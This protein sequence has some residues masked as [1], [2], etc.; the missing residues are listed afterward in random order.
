MPYF[1]LR[2]AANAPVEVPGNSEPEVKANIANNG[3]VTHTAHSRSTTPVAPQSLAL[4][5]AVSAASVCVLCRASVGQVANA[6]LAEAWVAAF[7]VRRSHAILK[8]KAEQAGDEDTADEQ[9]D[10][11]E[12]AAEAE[13][14]ARAK[15]YAS[16]TA[17]P[18]PHA[19]AADTGAA[20]ANTAA[21][22]PYAD[23]KVE[24]SSAVT[25]DDFM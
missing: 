22:N 4:T 8:Q 12:A 13:E 1:S 3:Q 6:A 21:A 5:A 24:P 10:L 19:T 7:F 2:T 25:D 17:P 9:F 14:A 23:V 18:Q 20:A 11:M 16:I 15:Y